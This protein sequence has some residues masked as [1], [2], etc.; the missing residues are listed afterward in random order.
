MKSGS[1]SDS[2]YR[3]LHEH[4]VDQIIA[5]RTESKQIPIVAG[6]AKLQ[7]EDREVYAAMR[8]ASIE[9]HDL[10][11]NFELFKSKVIAE[12]TTRIYQKMIGSRCSHAGW[13]RFYWLL[14]S[15]TLTIPVPHVRS[16]LCGF[17]RAQSTSNGF[18]LE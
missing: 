18:V 13:Q 2:S 16:F 8:D 6:S 5:G 1:P 11:E 14:G 10:K 3:T 12:K 4:T 15:Y 7:A 17:S 9:A